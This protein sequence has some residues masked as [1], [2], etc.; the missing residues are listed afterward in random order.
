MMSSS[1]FTFVHILI[2]IFSLKSTTT[3]VSVP[4]TY[5]Q[6]RNIVYTG[7]NVHLLRTNDVGNAHVCANRSEISSQISPHISKSMSWA[8]LRILGI[9]VVIVLELAVTIFLCA[10]RTFGL[11]L[12]RRGTGF[13]V[14]NI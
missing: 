11:R 6:K 2:F 3:N 5:T 7:C 12:H 14:Y 4:N 13:F 9:P 10:Q 8:N 1:S